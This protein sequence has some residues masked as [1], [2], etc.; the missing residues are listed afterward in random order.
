MYHIILSFAII[1]LFSF[2]KGNLF[3]HL[4]FVLLACMFSTMPEEIPDVSI[5]LRDFSNPYEDY[6]AASLEP[7]FWLLN[8][9]FGDI[10]Q[11][12]FGLFLFVLTFFMME[13]WYYTTKRLLPRDNV[14]FCFLL[15]LS[16]NGFFYMGVTLRNAL[17]L[18]ICYFAL[19]VLC[20]TRG[21]KRYLYYILL[22]LLAI[23]FHR[24]SF[25]FLLFLL[26]DG[27]VV[28]R[29]KLNYWMLINVLLLFVG[30]I[31]LARF[32]N[33]F[34][35]FG[36]LDKYGEF[37]EESRGVSI[38]SVWFLMNF[39]SVIIMLRVRKYVYPDYIGIFDFFLKVSMIG[40]SFNFAGWQLGTIQ[41]LA[42]A[43]YFFNFIPLYIAFF[44]S[45][46]IKKMKKR[47]LATI[48]FSIFS[49][50]VLLYCQSFMIYY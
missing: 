3:R 31:L 5:Y 38:L 33:Y 29:E 12:P 32:S 20:T 22:L 17:S 34:F 15:F 28:N 46:F 40:L 39:I 44:E 27:I 19:M 42:G 6:I 13:L 30:I 2:Y 25:L 21:G 4:T 24:T 10:L 50:M 26:V 14:G 49:F 37:V 16:Y 9:F 48:Y 18:M 43:F 1:I 41:R 11:I 45:S 8:V 47:Q 35:G 7:G 23:S 36:G